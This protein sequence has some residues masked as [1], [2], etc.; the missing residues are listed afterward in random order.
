MMLLFTAVSAY[1]YY[2]GDVSDCGC[3]AK[4][5]KRENDWKLIVENT[6]IIFLLAL[7]FLN[8]KKRK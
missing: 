2:T 3:Y 6:L 1:R 7:N 5:L 4:F 8:F